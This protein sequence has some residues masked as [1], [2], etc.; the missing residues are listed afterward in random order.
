MLIGYCKV[1]ILH[2]NSQCCLGTRIQKVLSSIAIFLFGPSIHYHDPVAGVMV[3]LTFL[4][5]EQITIHTSS[6]YY[7]IILTS[8]EI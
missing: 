5:C 6:F 1:G 8:N 7:Q 2:V 4:I 3:E